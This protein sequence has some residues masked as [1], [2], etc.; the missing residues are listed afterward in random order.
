LEFWLK[1]Q[2]E[3]NALDVGKFYKL[4]V[5]EKTVALKINF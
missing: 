5:K 1:K 2:M 4:S 3:K